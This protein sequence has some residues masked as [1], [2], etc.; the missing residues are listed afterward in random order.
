MKRPLLLFVLFFFGVCVISNAQVGSA[1]NTA[2]FY[3]NY[4]DNPANISPKDIKVGLLSSL[5]RNDFS[6]VNATVAYFN[7]PLYQ[8]QMG[9]GVRVTS[10]SAGGAKEK[11]LNVGGTYNL[12]IAGDTLS[13]GLEIGVLQRNFNLQGLL[14]DDETDPFLS[15]DGVNEFDQNLNVGLYF[16]PRNYV[17]SVSLKSL[18]SMMISS[19]Y[20][21]NHFALWGARKFVVSDR[22][23]LKT[24]VKVDKFNERS[25]IYSLMSEGQFLG[26]GSVSAAYSSIKMIS[27]QATLLM[28]RY[29]KVF[30]PIVLGYSY[31]HNLSEQTFYSQLTHQLFINY[32]FR[33][34]PAK[35]KVRKSSNSINPN[36]Y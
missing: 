2:F 27:L 32:S 3:N 20:N 8:Q 1:L 10:K 36:Y 17:F 23:S 6:G 25:A 13:M 18:N 15:D 7:S 4:I 28:N 33:K 14:V 5:G 31:N 30:D 16:S 34:K 9:V 22:F 12:L 11:R 24:G 21:D 26:I 19:D 35:A 29:F